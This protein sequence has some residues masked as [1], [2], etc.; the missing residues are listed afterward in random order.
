[1][2]KDD[3]RQEY[4][5]EI[6]IYYLNGHSVSYIRGVDCD[7]IFVDDS[8]VTIWMKNLTRVIHGMP[9]DLTLTHEEEAK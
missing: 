3:C 4:V 8:T 6:N 2:T 9:Y 1:M 5:R 7:N